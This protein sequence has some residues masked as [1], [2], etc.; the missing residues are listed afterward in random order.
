MSNSIPQAYNV[1]TNT[2]DN[3][4]LSVGREPGGH[5]SGG[6]VAEGANEVGDQSSNVGGGL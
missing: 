1:L 6:G 2:T 4:R 5:C 3:A